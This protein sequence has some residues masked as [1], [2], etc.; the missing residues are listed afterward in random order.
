MCF[1]LIEG[2]LFVL[3]FYY[4]LNASAEPLFMYDQVG[5][6]SRQLQLMDSFLVNCFLVVSAINLLIYLLIILQV[7]TYRQYSVFLIIITLILV[8]V[9]QVESY[10]F[11]YLTNYYDESQ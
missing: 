6:Y 8:Y 1:W 10:Q 4:A 7:N 2:F 9:L 5:F 3:F 11:Y